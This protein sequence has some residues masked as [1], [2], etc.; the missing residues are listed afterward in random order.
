MA[1]RRRS[2]SGKI[3]SIELDS[4][5]SYVY[6]NGEIV[7]GRVTLRSSSDED[8]Y[9]IIIQLTA[10]GESYVGLAGRN[11]TVGLGDQWAGQVMLD[12][13][14]QLYQGTYKLRKDVTYEW[15]FKMRFPTSMSHVTDSI[16]IAWKAPDDEQWRYDD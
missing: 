16:G 7:S 9:S 3:L 4:P 2:S 13:H 15:P 8:V 10:I 11:Q 6:T 1:D 14:Q 5:P 12:M